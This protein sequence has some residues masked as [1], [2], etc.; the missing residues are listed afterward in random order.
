MN[1][2]I[3]RSVIDDLTFLKDYLAEKAQTYRHGQVSV[4]DRFTRKVLQPEI[5]RLTATPETYTEELTISDELVKQLAVVAGVDILTP[6]AS[7]TSKVPEV[8]SPALG[9][10]TPNEF[11]VP[12]AALSG[13][14]HKKEKTRGLTDSERDS[15]RA[16]FLSLDG[17]IEEDACVAIKRGMNDDVAIFQVTGFVSY[18]HKE[19]A[20]GAL[21]LRDLEGYI[22]WMK[23]KYPKLL[24]QYN[25]EKYRL[26][27][28]QIQPTYTAS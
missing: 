26:L 8:K 22:E 16:F 27:R 3:T 23:A 12:V 7:E 25:S 6:G 20:S 2:N 5:D 19:V 1:L 24:E 17:Q 13:N 10:D 14:N 11:Q 28:Q 21:K 4:I 9:P 18:L 15:L